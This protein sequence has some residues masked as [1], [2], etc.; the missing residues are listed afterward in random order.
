[1]RTLTGDHGECRRYLCNVWPD[2]LRIV[3][4]TLDGRDGQER[5]LTEVSTPIGIK[6]KSAFE[7]AF[8]ISHESTEHGLTSCCV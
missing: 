2:L 1:V 6:Q 5:M 3:Y 8:S 4:D 7:A